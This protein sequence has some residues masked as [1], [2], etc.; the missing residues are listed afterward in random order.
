MATLNKSKIIKN[1]DK[2]KIETPYSQYGE[3]IVNPNEHFKLKSNNAHFPS[4][5]LHSGSRFEIVNDPHVHTPIRLEINK[6]KLTPNGPASLI[7]FFDF[8]RI[9]LDGNNG[10]RGYRGNDAR[11][12]ASSIIEA[13]SGGKGGDGQNGLTLSTRGILFLSINEIEIIPNTPLSRAIFNFDAKGCKGGNGGQ[14]GNG[15]NGGD[16]VLGISGAHKCNI[17]GCW[18][19]R[20]IKSGS[21]GGNGGDGGNPGNGANGGGGALIYFRG[22][23]SVFN[24]I[25]SIIDL[26]GGNFGLGG[27]GGAGGAGGNGAPSVHGG[28]GHCGRRHPAQPAGKSGEYRNILSGSNGVSGQ[29]GKFQKVSNF[30]TYEEIINSVISDINNEEGFF[31]LL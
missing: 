22:P 20:G 27:Y 6:L 7:S 8:D 3:L 10:I 19:T 25:K 9:D 26:D 1:L 30:P 13:T 31:N 23:K 11:R 18:C 28:G 5:T 17:A 4:V 16:G 24:A 15:G 14:G 2:I 29:L 12:N 21:P